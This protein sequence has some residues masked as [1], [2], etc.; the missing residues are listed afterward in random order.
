MLSLY[1][2]FIPI[3]TLTCFHRVSDASIIVVK[4]DNASVTVCNQTES[5]TNPC[6]SLQPALLAMES[7]SKMIIS[8]GDNYT[9]SYD[10]AMTMY[11]MNSIV[12]VGDGSD[13][14][15]ITCN[16]NAGLAF[17]NMNGITIANLTKEL[18]SLEE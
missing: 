8:A 9:L 17:I 14:T 16:S 13:N 11:G 5:Q 15:V 1:C 3:L 4:Q 18:W 2:Q 12:I 6:T 10:D 7:G